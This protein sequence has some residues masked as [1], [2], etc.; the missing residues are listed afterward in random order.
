MKRAAPE[1]SDDAVAALQRHR[2]P[3]NIRELENELRR[4]L[5]LLRD[6]SVIEARHFSD[7]VRGNT[8]QKPTAH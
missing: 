3:G 6:E 2:W 1:L 5:A 8:N 7:D 4:C